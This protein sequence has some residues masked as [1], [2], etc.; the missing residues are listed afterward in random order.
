MLI[1]KS[2]LI[3][4][5]IYQHD[6]IEILKEGTKVYNLNGTSDD[7]IEMHLLNGESK[8]FPSAIKA[9]R[10]VLDMFFDNHFDKQNVFTSFLKRLISNICCNEC[11]DDIFSPY[12]C[13]AHVSLSSSA[14][15]KKIKVGDQFLIVPLCAKCNKIP[16]DEPIIL[17]YDI[18]AVVG[19]WNG[20]KYDR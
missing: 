16:S 2:S 18:P 1:K 7:K 11:C 10:A 17:A 15:Y 3:E 19:T 14:P 12:I 20:E 9:Y 13:G 4:S 6:C 5:F 8:I